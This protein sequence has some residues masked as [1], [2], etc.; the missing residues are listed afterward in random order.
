MF[1]R[2]PWELWLSQ[3]NVGETSPASQMRY[4]LD[5]IDPYDLDSVMGTYEH[6]FETILSP[7]GIRP[8]LMIG[9]KMSLKTIALMLFFQ[10]KF[11]S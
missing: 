5:N 4:A 3:E 1:T 8:V 10:L 11:S 9:K 6:I 2:A 7:L